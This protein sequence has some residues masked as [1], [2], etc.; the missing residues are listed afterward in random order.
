MSVASLMASPE[1]AG[2]FQKAIPQS[3]A[4]HNALSNEET[5][6]TAL[7]FCEALGVAAD[8]V[9]ALMAADPADILAASVAVDPIASSGVGGRDGRGRRLSDPADAL[10]AGDRRLVSLVVAD[11]P[12]SQRLR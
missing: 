7:K 8:D 6:A 4:G 11:R 10:P 12:H 1:A 2:L 3:G 5:N 9:D